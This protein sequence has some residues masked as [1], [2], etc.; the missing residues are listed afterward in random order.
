[1]AGIF[2]TLGQQLIGSG[3][4]SFMPDLFPA[5]LGMQQQQA[6]Q[7]APAPL[8]Y[9]MHGANENSPM[10]GIAPLVNANVDPNYL[11]GLGRGMR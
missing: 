9:G 4:H 1:M 3:L 11:N 8:W 2:G 5:N 7:H 6:Q 10:S